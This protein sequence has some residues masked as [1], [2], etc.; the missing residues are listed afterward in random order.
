MTWWPSSRSSAP[1]SSSAARC[2]VPTRAVSIGGTL[3]LN[4]IR[5]RP[6]A[7]RAAATKLPSG[8]GVVDV[9]SRNSAASSTVLAIGPLTDRPFHAPSCGASGTRSRC[10]LIPN[11][12]HQ[13]DGIRIDPMPSEPSAIAARPAATA[14]PLPP[15]LPPGVRLVSHGFRVAPNVSVSVNDQSIISGT[16]VLPTMT[17][18][19]AR[20]L[21]TTSAS[22]VLAGP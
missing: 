3:A 20:S 19:A 12:P 8:A 5:N 13:A 1:A 17:A 9:T 18:P 22:S 21:R 16:A 6:G 14:A 15:L 11:R 7:R 4:A 2:A 10:G